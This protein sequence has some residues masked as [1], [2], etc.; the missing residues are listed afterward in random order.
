MPE[1]TQQVENGLGVFVDEEGEEIFVVFEFHFGVWWVILL[2]CKVS[3]CFARY[4]AFNKYLTSC[5][6]IFKSAISYFGVK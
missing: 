4:S 6:N 5:Y 1:V 3:D 2:L